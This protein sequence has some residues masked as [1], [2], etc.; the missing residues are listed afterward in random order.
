MY[1]STNNLETINES[2]VLGLD[3]EA[4]VPG[5]LN[6]FRGF[7]VNRERK[8]LSN[9]N[10]H[11][12]WGA[13]VTGGTAETTNINIWETI[14]NGL[15]VKSVYLFGDE[16]TPLTARHVHGV[17]YRA[18]DDSWWVWT[19]DFESQSNWIKGSY[20]EGTGAWT[21]Q[22]IRV[23]SNQTVYQDVGINFRSNGDVL[24]N[25]ENPYELGG[26]YRF[27]YEDI[28]TI[29]DQ[30][31]M[32]LLY[33]GIPVILNIANVF[34]DASNFFCTSY[35][36]D[37]AA[38]VFPKL[39]IVYTFDLQNFVFEQITPWVGAAFT[40][41][42]T[43]IVFTGWKLDNGYYIFVVYDDTETLDNYQKGKYIYIKFYNS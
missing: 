40:S 28:G 14:D 1:Y 35:T 3:G 30:T 11:V 21:W 20:N 19:G 5:T 43:G 16:S 29:V 24:L 37:F 18:T 13:Y 23:G 8:L 26:L 32:E 27:A 34:V 6:N 31:D 38:T 17:N 9:G 4:F 7:E 33:R 2:T 15:T 12:V 22:S 42:N 39:S 25:V 41:G 36:A 10:E